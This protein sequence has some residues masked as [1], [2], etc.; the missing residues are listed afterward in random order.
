MKYILLRHGQTVGNLEK[1]YIGCRTDE[2]LCSQGKLTLMNRHYPKADYV[3]VSPMRRC[4]ETAQIIY[5]NIPKEIVADFREC[6]FGE[7]ENRSYQELNLRQDYRKWLASGGTLP[8]PGG[9]SRSEFVARCVRAFQRCIDGKID[10]IYA[11][12][13]HGGTIMAIMEAL[14]RSDKNYYAFQVENGGG[15]VLD[16]MG[17]Y[18]KLLFEMS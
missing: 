12:V 18:K 17:N 15:F 16:E 8:V 3:Y 1:R 14:T 5:P 6:D 10:G 11:F 13:V 7:Y 2:P 4:L 9:E